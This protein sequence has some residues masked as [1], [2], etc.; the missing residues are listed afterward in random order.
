MS[1][2][3]EATIETIKKL[4]DDCTV[5]DIMYEINFIGQVYEGIKDA[6]GGKLVTTSELLETVKTW[7]R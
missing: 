7:G 1:P 2:I 5:E 4:P 3:K 6:D